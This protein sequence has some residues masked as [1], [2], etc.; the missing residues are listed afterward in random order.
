MAHFCILLSDV[1]KED[2]PEK[3]VEFLY[4]AS[5]VALIIAFVMTHIFNSKKQSSVEQ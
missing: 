1:A 2:I 3:L 5:S 4:F